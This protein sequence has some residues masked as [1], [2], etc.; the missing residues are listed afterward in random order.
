MLRS[1]NMRKKQFIF[2]VFISLYSVFEDELLIFLSR[3]IYSK[4]LYP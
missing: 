2:G 1:L 3:T 4:T